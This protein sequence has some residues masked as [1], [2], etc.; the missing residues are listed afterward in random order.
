M[1]VKK[2]SMAL[3][4]QYRDISVLLLFFSIN[5]ARPA[6]NCHM[7]VVSMAEMVDWTL[8]PCGKLCL[9]LPCQVQRVEYCTSRRF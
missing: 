5:N 3:A 9:C 1:H 8:N 2:L 4:R 6:G 7:E